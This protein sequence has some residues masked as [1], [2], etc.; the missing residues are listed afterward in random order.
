LFIKSALQYSKLGT[1]VINTA[2]RSFICFE[3]QAQL[4]LQRTFLKLINI[5]KSTPST[6]THQILNSDAQIYKN[7]RIKAA[8]NTTDT[9]IT[10]KQFN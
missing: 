4:W 8:L 6:R 9:N 5:H 7:T 10:K 1:L 3:K 2:M